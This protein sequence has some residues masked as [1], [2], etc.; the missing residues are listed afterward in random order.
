[1]PVGLFWGIV[2][3][4]LGLLIAAVVYHMVRNWSSR[5]PEAPH[6]IREKDELSVENALTRSPQ[7]WKNLAREYFEKGEYTPA[8]RALYLSLL[9]VLHRR[10]LISYETS[11]TNWEYV[12]ELISP[13]GERIPFERLTSA[14]DYKWYGRYECTRSD[15]LKLERLADALVE[16]DDSS[17]ADS[18]SRPE[19]GNTKA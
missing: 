9:V 7:Q 1:M 12:W 16:G 18:P 8:L 14:F 6:A 19:T 13:R 11:K 4:L 5:A 17:D 3:G 10:R 2:I 15:Y